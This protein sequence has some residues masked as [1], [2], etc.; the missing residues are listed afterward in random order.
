MVFEDYHIESQNNNM[1]GF[2]INLENL[3]RA[4]KSAQNVPD[5]QIKLTKKAGQPVLSFCMEMVRVR[6]SV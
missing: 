6:A 5:T 1:I 2:E 4:L 3:V